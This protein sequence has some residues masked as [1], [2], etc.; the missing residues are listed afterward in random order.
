MKE[1][2][3]NTERLK[4]TGQRY[5]LSNEPPIPF[6]ITHCPPPISRSESVGCEIA[7]SMMR[8]NLTE[9]SVDEHLASQWRTPT[10]RNNKFGI[11]GQLSL[12]MPKQ[13]FDRPTQDAIVRSARYGIVHHRI[14]TEPPSEGTWPRRFP[15]VLVVG[16]NSGHWMIVQLRSIGH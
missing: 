7:V 10:Y 14:G 8:N 15:T 5:R 3:R 4:K 16:A 13:E 12:L 1:D 9:R 11:G 2:E 6:D